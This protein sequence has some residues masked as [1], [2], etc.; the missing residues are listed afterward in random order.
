MRSAELGDLSIA[1]SAEMEI[2]RL[3]ARRK[4]TG[5]ALSGLVN[6]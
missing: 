1:G 3:L 4:W 5:V 2:Y 6:A